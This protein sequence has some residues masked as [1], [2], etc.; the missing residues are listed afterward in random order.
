MTRRTA[1]R[2][3]PDLKQEDELTQSDYETLAAFRLALRHFA[4]FSAG[5]AQEAGLTTH[6]HQA[7]LAIKGCPAGKAAT[8]GHLAE[9]LLV[10]ANTAAEFV[11]RLES[12]GLVAKIADPDD[13]RRVVLKL[14]PRAETCLRRLTLAHRN[15]VRGLAPRLL[16][17]FGDLDAR[18]V[19]DTRS[20]ITLATSSRQSGEPRPP[21]R[22]QGK[23]SR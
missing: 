5:A 7:L 6:Q 10:A 8:V 15:E 19:P 17:L 2:A 13:R 14:T 4:N 16:A 21:M 12:S 1:A 18:D 20:K 11:A 3:K 22:S 23:S 9:Q